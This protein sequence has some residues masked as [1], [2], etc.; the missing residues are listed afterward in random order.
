MPPAAGGPAC[1]GAQRPRASKG[2]AHRIRSTG[3][4]SYGVLNARGHR[5]GSHLKCPDRFILHGLCSTPEGIEGGRTGNVG[6]VHFGLW[7]CSTPEGIEGGRTQPAS[8]NQWQQARVLNARGHRRGSHGR[9]ADAMIRASGC[10]TPEGI[11]GGRTL[12]PIPCPAYGTLVLNARGH[13]RGSHN[14]TPPKHYFDK[15]CS[16]PEGIEGGRTPIPRAM[17]LAPGRCST[18]EGI[19]G[20]RTRGT[21]V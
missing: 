15:M 8:R 16:T 12:N 2:V 9:H 3:G 7:Q 14:I 13:R 5:R 18:P 10:S 6:L 19:E 21:G 1:P 11:E 17:D 4:A 20:G